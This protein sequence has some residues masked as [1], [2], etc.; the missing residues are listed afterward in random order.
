MSIQLGVPGEFDGFLIW[1]T[2]TLLMEAK[3]QQIRH[4]N[5]SGC[6]SYNYRRLKIYTI[7]IYLVMC[8]CEVLSCELLVGINAYTR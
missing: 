8:V 2:C 1:C 3:N 5:V 6:S 7:F 4:S